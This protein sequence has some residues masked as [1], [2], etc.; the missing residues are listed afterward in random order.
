MK[1]VVLMA[2]SALIGCVS[3]TLE[4]PGDQRANPLVQSP[5]AEQPATALKPG[6]DPFSAYP[7]EAAAS[8]P[9]GKAAHHHAEH[10]GHSMPAMDHA[11]HGEQATPAADG[12]TEAGEKAAPSAVYTCPMHPEIVRNAPGKCP[13]CGMDL[14]PK[15]SEKPRPHH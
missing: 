4:T 12:G 15:K 10:S 13:K 7:E 6:F 8:E 9:A 14:V 2:A 3:T 11:A 5:K 1:V